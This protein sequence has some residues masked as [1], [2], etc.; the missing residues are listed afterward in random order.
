MYPF[1]EGFTKKGANTVCSFI[2]H[3]L[4]KEFNRNKHTKITLFSDAA[5]LQNRN[6]T[7]LTFLILLSIE[8]KVEILHVFPVRDHSYCQCDANF[9]LLGRKKKIRNK[10]K[11]LKTIVL[12]LKIAATLLLLMLTLQLNC[13][14]IFIRF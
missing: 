1:L 11:L 13:Y 9:G 14:K 12:C 3:A 10:L 8:L 4:K 5:G 2:Y 6:Y 7:V